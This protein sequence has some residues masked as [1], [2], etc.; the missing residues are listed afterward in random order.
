MRQRSKKSV[1]HRVGEGWEDSMIEKREVPFRC[2]AGARY[3]YVDEHGLVSYCSQR[4]SDPGVPVLD[5]Q[6]RDLLEAFETPKGCEASCTIACVRRASAMDE[7]RPQSRPAR[8]PRAVTH[9]PVV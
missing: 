6:R 7:W 1:F 3:L 9:L 8:P 4:R 5:Y 2:R